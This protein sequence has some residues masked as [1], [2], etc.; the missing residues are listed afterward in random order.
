MLR[1]VDPEGRALHDLD[2]YTVY[3][4]GYIVERVLFTQTVRSDPLSS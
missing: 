4:K 2:A 3:R 1:I